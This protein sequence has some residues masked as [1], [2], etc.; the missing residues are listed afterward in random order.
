MIGKTFS[1]VP[2]MKSTHQATIVLFFISHLTKKTR[3][4][5]I[6]ILMIASSL[7]VVVD[8]QQETTTYKVLEYLLD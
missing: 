1:V 5:S 8:N 3:V 2:N 4:L 6:T 7:V